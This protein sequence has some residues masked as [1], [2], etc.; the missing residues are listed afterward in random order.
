M[1]PPHSPSQRAT[2][3][4][5]ERERGGAPRRGA[6]PHSLCR[7]R[8]LS[9]RRVRVGAE[10]DRLAG[11]GA[12]EPTSRGGLGSDSLSLSLLG[13]RTCLLLP[14]LRQGS[15][16]TATSSLLRLMSCPMVKGCWQYP[17]S[18][19]G[20]PG[21]TLVLG[22]Q[23]RKMRT[24]CAPSLVAS[25]C[26]F[27]LLSCLRGSRVARALARRRSLTSTR[28]TGRLGVCPGER[29]LYQSARR[30]SP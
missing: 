27:C 12:S 7:E 14:H 4:E 16:L 17:R 22:K 9:V 23:Q 11:C 15:D 20:C 26:W 13:C 3:A 30:A 18:V 19:D 8:Q 6:G 5:R 21:H 10:L 1:L 28:L 25:Q 24:R 29:G 2:A